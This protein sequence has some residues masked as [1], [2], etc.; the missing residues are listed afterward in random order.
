MNEADY[1][2]LYKKTRV[3]LWNIAFMFCG[4]EQLAEDAVQEGFM[5][6]FRR[7]EKM[8]DPDKARGFVFIAARNYIYN[9]LRKTRNLASWQAE[10]DEELLYEDKRLDAAVH[11][12]ARAMLDDRRL[13]DRQREI[14][15]LRYL[16][17]M[18]MRSIGKETGA[19]SATVHDELHCVYEY[20]KERM[21][22]EGI[23][24]EDF[25]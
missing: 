2:A 8:R 9:Y 21:E 5:K 13:T 15:E 20:L 7:I 12:A 10:Y 18:T 1:I 25:L 14:W 4:D 23:G 16:G 24:P 6:A 19:S 11:R 22:S 17:D 3:P